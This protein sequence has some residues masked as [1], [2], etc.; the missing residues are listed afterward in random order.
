[1]EINEYHT[2]AGAWDIHVPGISVQQAGIPFLIGIGNPFYFIGQLPFQDI[3][4]FKMIMLMG[5]R[6]IRHI[7]EL[8]EPG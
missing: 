1:M 6:I 8:M 5:N 3:H 7:A 4:Q 2:A